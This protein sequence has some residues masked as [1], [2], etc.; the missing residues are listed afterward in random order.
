M[1]LFDRGLGLWGDFV[2]L[3]FAPG[4]F[5]LGVRFGPGLGSLLRFFGGFGTP[6]T[7]P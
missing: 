2:G 5:V 3:K 6:C 1:K 4:V 7:V